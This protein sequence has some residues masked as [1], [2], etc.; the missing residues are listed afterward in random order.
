MKKNVVSKAL[1]FLNQIIL[2]AHIKFMKFSFDD[3]NKQV[4]SDDFEQIYQ[5]I[6]SAIMPLDFDE[7]ACSPEPRRETKK[8]KDPITPL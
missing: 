3:S 8:K 7:N 4:I 5:F 1:Q 2:L 6:E